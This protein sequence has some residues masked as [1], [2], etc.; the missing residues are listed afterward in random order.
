MT[1]EQRFD[2]LVSTL[3][4]NFKGST[5]TLCCVDLCNEGIYIMLCHESTKNDILLTTIRLQVA[6]ERYKITRKYIISWA[7]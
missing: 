5:A 6:D 1:F 3:L 7:V 4:S 2:F